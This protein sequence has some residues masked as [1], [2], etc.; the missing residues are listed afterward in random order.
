MMTKS[1]VEIWVSKMKG[2]YDRYLKLALDSVNKKRQTL[3]KCIS[4]EFVHVYQG[5]S[6]I[7]YSA[8]TSFMSADFH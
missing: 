3:G 8:K 7:S 2:D 5:M 4:G 6:C 1:C